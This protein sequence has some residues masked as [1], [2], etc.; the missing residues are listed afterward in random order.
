MVQP[1]Y[2]TST[3]LVR[4]NPLSTNFKWYI[5]VTKTL[6][7]Y[8]KPTL[9]HFFMFRKTTEVYWV[10]TNSLPLFPVQPNGVYTTK[11][12]FKTVTNPDKRRLLLSSSLWK[13]FFQTK[14]NTTVCKKR[15]KTTP[16]SF[17]KLKDSQQ[18]L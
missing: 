2:K 12:I 4:F 6:N 7:R 10:G 15:T 18:Y 11:G 14:Q 9:Y 3:R 13:V 5:C 1:V 16:L 8:T 17:G